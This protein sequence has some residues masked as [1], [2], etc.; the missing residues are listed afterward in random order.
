MIARRSGWIPSMKSSDSQSAVQAG[1]RGGEVHRIL[2]SVWSA[3]RH[4]ELAH[5]SRAASRGDRKAVRLLAQAAC[6]AD[7]NRAA[8]AAEA[9]SSL[10]NRD[11]IECLCEC[12]LHS[13]NGSLDSL[14][15]LNG[16][17]PEDEEIRAAFYLATGQIDRY[18]DL[19]I[20]EDRPLLTGGFHR[21]PGPA[22]MKVLS[23]A[24]RAGMGAVMADIVSGHNAPPRTGCS[25]KEWRALAQSLAQASEWMRI[26]RLLFDAPVPVAVE[27]LAMLKSAGW[28]PGPHDEVSWK[29]LA[30]LLPD[31]WTY[32]DPPAEPAV[33]LDGPREAVNRMV[34]HTDGHLLATGS[35]DGTV[36]LFGLPG[37]ALLHSIHTGCGQI[38]DLR[39]SPD[40]R[41]LAAA[42]TDPGICLIDP[43]ER[44]VVNTIGKEAG[45]ASHLVF[46]PDSDSLVHDGRGGGIYLTRVETGDTT[47]LFSGE[48]ECVTGLFS[49]PSGGEIFWGT[50]TG[51]I[52]SLTSEGGEITEYPGHK[53]PATFVSVTCSGQYLV[54]AATIGR[55]RIQDT[56]NGRS[57]G[58][59]GS[60]GLRCTA[61]AVAP[62]KEVCAFATGKGEISVIGIPGGRVQAS[63][64]VYKEGGV[65]ALAFSPDGSVLVAGGRSGHIHIWRI[66]DCRLIRRVK[67]HE[68]TVKCISVNSAGTA[69]ASSGWDGLIT[70]HSLAD[71]RLVH[72]MKVDPAGISSLAPAGDGGLIIYGTVNGNVR[73]RSVPDGGLAAAFSAYTPGIHSIAV[74]SR[75]SYV[76]CAGTDRTVS[77]WRIRDGSLAGSIV[78][79]SGNIH[80]LAVQ[81]GDRLIAG[82]GWDHLVRLWSFPGGDLQAELSGHRSLVS[83]LAFSHD[84]AFLC[85]GSNDRTARVWGADGECL[86]VCEG[87]RH[88]ISCIAISPDNSLLFTGSRDGTV[89]TWSLPDGRELACLGHH[90]SGLSALAC[91]PDPGILAAGCEDGSIRLWGLPD[92]EVIRQFNDHASPVRG[93]AF[94]GDGNVLVAG[95]EDG[96][97]RSRPLPWTKPLG[98]ALPEDLEWVSRQVMDGRAGPRSSR[99]QWEFLE[100]LL[101]VKFRW[102]IGHCDHDTRIGPFDIEIV[103]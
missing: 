87:H 36:T 47:A 86:S 72:S 84:G 13:E 88:V 65:T 29:R 90:P 38:H 94:T 71:G 77:I 98:L 26:W 44:R 75:G 11:A 80:S 15:I 3:L 4:R 56:G 27:M 33:V 23:T 16:Y 96:M 68:S 40:G 89:R 102:E 91:G 21:V 101:R 97:L 58:R 99:Y 73:A 67:A 60:D 76:T 70:L 14:C 10:G 24:R 103:E 22:R 6:G 31:T 92:G 62:G 64:G 79:N 61:V 42:G 51:R 28:N 37:G 17:A 81:P 52:R 100:T 48:R 35:Y 46:L 85:S 20:L 49:S 12:L 8:R 59:A 69:V 7:G 25:L 50:E 18:N 41:M 63:F 32:P 19:D 93:L 39:F 53:N 30:G 54:S 57:A 95:Y 1:V 43:V 74:D 9:L 5:L 82:G 78:G 66:A 45:A 34:L 83:C 2:P 55:I